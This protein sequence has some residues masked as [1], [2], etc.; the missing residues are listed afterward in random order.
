M[1]ALPIVANQ[2]PRRNYSLTSGVMA[3]RCR[4]DSNVTCV[5][6][7]AVPVKPVFYNG[8]VAALAAG[9]LSV[10]FTHVSLA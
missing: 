1:R 4:G 6:G 7:D 10:V 3:A 9:S 5:D 8:G 2:V